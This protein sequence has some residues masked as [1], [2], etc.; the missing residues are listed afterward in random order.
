MTDAEKAVARQTY[1]STYYQKNKEKQR[2]YSAA[3][4]QEH[5]EELLSHKDEIRA[6]KALRRDSIAEQ[7]CRYAAIFREKLIALRTATGCRGEGPHKGLLHYHHRD[8]STKLYNVSNMWGY[9]A[10]AFEEEVAK[11]DV[12]CASCHRREHVARQRKCSLGVQSTEEGTDP[13]IAP[14]SDSDCSSDDSEGRHAAVHEP[15]KKLS[16][17]K[18][19]IVST[20]CSVV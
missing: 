12:L 14:V 19:L 1:H 9:A 20:M 18:P 2:A 7:Q 15:L 3:Y 5:R 10:R 11:C 13:V 4:Y 6:R 16:L 17:E 8:P